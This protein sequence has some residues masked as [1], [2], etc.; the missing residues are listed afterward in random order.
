MTIYHVA[1]DG[2]EDFTTIAEVNAATFAPGDNILFNK[3]DTW[4]ERLVIPSSGSFGSP[5]TFSSYGSGSQPS[6]E[7]FFINVKNFITVSEL[8]FVAVNS[9]AGGIN[10]SHDISIINCELDG[11]S[12]GTYSTCL[13]VGDYTGNIHSYNILVDG[14]VAHNAGDIAVHWYGGGIKFN[15]SVHDSIIRNCTVYDNIETNIQSYSTYS[16]DDWN[17]NI[18]IENNTVYNSLPFDVN[19]ETGINVGWNCYD[20]VVSGNFVYNCRV[21]IQVDSK[22][23]D[24]VIKNNIVMNGEQALIR[25]LANTYGACENTEIYNNTLISNNDTCSIGIYMIQSVYPSTGHLIKN[26]IISV[27]NTPVSGS[28]VLSNPSFDTDTSYWF[29]YFN[30]TNGASGSFARTTTAGEY[31]SGAGG[32]KL[33]ITDSGTGISDVQLFN[34]PITTVSG[35]WYR[36]QFWAKS[37]IAMSVLVRILKS[38]SPYTNYYSESIGNTQSISSSWELHTVYFN[39]NTDASDGRLCFYL[40]AVADSSIFYLDSVSMLPCT[41]PF[42]FIRATQGNSFFSADYNDYYNAE[43]TFLTEYGSTSYNSLSDWQAT[44]QD[45]NSIVSNPLLTSDYHIPRTSPCIDSGTT[46]AEVTDD[47]EGNPRP[48]GASTD[49]G[50][51]EYYKCRIRNATL[52]NVSV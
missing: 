33:T 12:N 10:G 36:V 23:H 38:T 18:T 32:G 52:K 5:I 29:S 15:T 20:H 48:M 35:T 13:S 43:G 4:A 19:E 16:D 22:V 51:Y 21:P 47:Y 24:T 34:Y 28:E 31:Y 37:S 26:N 39:C 45:S 50:A 1:T 17:Y 11:N 2:S 49:I 3:G 41:A 27:S 44:G 42:E 8:K 9:Q 7:G 46:L 6:I 40:G 14:C 25:L 30:A